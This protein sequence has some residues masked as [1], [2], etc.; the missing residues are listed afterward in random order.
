MSQN[1]HNITA[2]V[3]T[4]NSAAYQP[5]INNILVSL[6]YLNQNLTLGVLSCIETCCRVPYDMPHRHSWRHGIQDALVCNVQGT[7]RRNALQ[8]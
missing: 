7:H 2:R 1:S 3:M 8:N 6:N 5:F 4:C